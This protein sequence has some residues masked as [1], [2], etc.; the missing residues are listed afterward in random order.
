MLAGSFSTFAGS[1][2]DSDGDGISDIVELTHGLNPDRRYDV[3]R[4][5]DHDH[6]PLI[7]ELQEGLDTTVGDNDV[8]NNKRLLIIG[9]IADIQ[10]RFASK[11]QIQYLLKA[12]FT[13]VELY[14]DL[15]DNHYLARMGFIGRVYQGLLLRKPDLD[16]ARYYHHQLGNGMSKEAM[17]G[18]F[19]HSNEFE[20]LYGELSN[21]DFVDHMY[22]N[23]YDR[24][25]PNELSEVWIQNLDNNVLTRAR[26]VQS[27]LRYSV[28]LIE[29][30]QYA[31]WLDVLALLITNRL[32]SDEVQQA[33][34]QFIQA[35]S[36]KVQAVKAQSNDNI[37]EQLL[38]QVHAD[39]IQGR[40]NTVGV[41]TALLM[42]DEF[43]QSR[44][45]N[46]SAATADTDNDGLFDGEEFVYGFDV[47]VKDNDVLGNDRLFVRQMLLDIN[48]KFVSNETLTAGLMA[49]KQAGSRVDWIK[50]LLAKNSDPAAK[51]FNALYKRKGSK[52]ELG[53]SQ[54]IGKLIDKVLSSSEYQSRFY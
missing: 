44:M 26:A 30:N 17:I 45:A 39:R 50:L 18:Q 16:G 54:D 42:S 13:P 31:N 41:L 19:V 8:F 23:I 48:G 34:R 46:I 20:G 3:W 35:R 53:H 38:Q 9:A 40:N 24:S 4:D 51:L 49:M 37:L 33:Y 22:L 10:S 14:Q 25:A 32:P 47:N 2:K 29:Q 12:D 43:R 1:A 27:I 28:R 52:A 21:R 5:L 7:V 36:I 6:L 11:N 15:L